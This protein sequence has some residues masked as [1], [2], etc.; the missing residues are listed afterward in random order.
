MEEKSR[1]TQDEAER[2]G[3]MF[4]FVYSMIKQAL[5]FK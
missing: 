5:G 4:R 1:S 3:W 2:L